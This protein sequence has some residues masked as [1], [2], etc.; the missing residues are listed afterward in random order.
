MFNFKQMF[1][2]FWF[3]KSTS[4]LEKT[5]R[6]NDPSYETLGSLCCR[7]TIGTQVEDIGSLDINLRRST[8][9][10]KGQ[11]ILENDTSTRCDN[12]TLNDVKNK[13][14]R[15]FELL[16]VEHGEDVTP[17][18]VKELF[19]GKKLFRYSFQQLICEY[20]KDRK[21]E[22]EAGIIT[23]STIDVHL[24]YSENFLEF[25]T[26]KGIKTSNTTHFDEDNLDSFKIFLSKQFAYS[27]T[28]KHLGWVKQL[29][30]HS[31]RKKRIK[32]NPLEGV[33]VSNEP[34][35]PDTSHPTIPELDRLI[36]FDF[37]RLHKL[38]FVVEETA[39]RLDRERD[40]FVFSSF[41]GMHHC[42]YTK[43]KYWL[44]DIKGAVF[45]KGFRKKTKK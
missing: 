41:T 11:R 35:K 2:L 34:D 17:M 29:F 3:R 36:N 37:F 39:A 43:R 20:F 26:E 21:E 27:H 4:M 28:R 6:K 14:E 7:I 15:I 13:L 1:V 30:K 33:K 38:G 19:T 5:N 24:N 23:Q 22:V 16:Q 18:M 44:E 42:D 10:E 45:L 12:R 31:L 9:D 8:W 40:A 25:L 32:F